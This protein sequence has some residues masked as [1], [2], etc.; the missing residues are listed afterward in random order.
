MAAKNGVDDGAD[1]VQKQAVGLM[2]LS[3][4]DFRNEARMKALLT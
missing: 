2:K 3:I 1:E 4:L